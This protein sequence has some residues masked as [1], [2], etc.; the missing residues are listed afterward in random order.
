MAMDNMLCIQFHICLLNANIRIRY[1]SK[2][3]YGYG[4]GK[5][6]TY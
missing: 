6:M 3:G 1:P 4:R 5:N 2:Y